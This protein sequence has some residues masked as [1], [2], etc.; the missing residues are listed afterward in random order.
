MNAE[1]IKYRLYSIDRK[2]M[3]ETPKE[4]YYG[5]PQNKYSDF[6]SIEEAYEAIDNWDEYVILPIISKR[7]F[8]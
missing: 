6:D 8:E 3:L 4:D 5:L 7:E 1:Y 2:G